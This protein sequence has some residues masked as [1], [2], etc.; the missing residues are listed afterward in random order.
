MQW[1]NYFLKSGAQYPLVAL[2]TALFV[3][4]LAAALQ[5][6]PTPW[7][8]TGSVAALRHVAAALDVRL[9]ALLSAASVVIFSGLWGMDPVTRR[10]RGILHGAIVLLI[11]ANWAA[12]VVALWWH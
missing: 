12:W 5:A 11:A 1:D 6:D 10:G 9:A 3:A 4:V 7:S 2:G 8:A